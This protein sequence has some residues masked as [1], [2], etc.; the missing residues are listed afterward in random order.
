[1]SRVSS[2]FS[3]DGSLGPTAYKMP[4]S[5][6]VELLYE[7]GFGRIPPEEKKL[8]HFPGELRFELVVGTAICGSE[9]FYHARARNIKRRKS[10]GKI[11]S[12]DRGLMQIKIDAPE[13]ENR[14]SL[15]AK[16]LWIPKFNVAHAFK[17]YKHRGWQPWYGYTNNIA[18]DP[19]TAGKYIQRANWAVMNFERK[20]LGLRQVPNPYIKLGRK[21]LEKWAKQNQD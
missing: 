13:F 10:D 2:E 6:V 3:Y 18:L 19:N 17:M 20:R 11:M 16:N 1:M 14:E 5:E 8:M 12:M 4:I 9:S 21:R 15:F 7:A